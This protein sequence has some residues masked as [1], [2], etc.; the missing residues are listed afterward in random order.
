MVTVVATLPSRSMVVPVCTVTVKQRQPIDDL[1]LLHHLR[2]K[3]SSPCK[4]EDCSPTDQVRS[5]TGSSTVH[6]RQHPLFSRPLNFFADLD[7]FGFFRH[8]YIYG[9]SSYS[10]HCT[11]KCSERERERERDQRTK[12]LSLLRCSKM[13]S[14]SA[15]DKEMFMSVHYFWCCSFSSLLIV[16]KNHLQRS[17]SDCFLSLENLFVSFLFNC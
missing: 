9:Y 10:S 15:K 17:T 13:W 5:A 1:G 7:W 16:G 2:H 4:H 3:P 8:I 14:F 11:K 6:I 12:T